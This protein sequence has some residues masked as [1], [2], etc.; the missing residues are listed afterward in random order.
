MDKTNEE[1]EI[2]NYLWCVLSSGI[3]ELR[4][5][6]KNEVITARQRDYHTTP[7]HTTIINVYN[8]QIA[9]VQHSTNNFAHL[10]LKNPNCFKETIKIVQNFYGIKS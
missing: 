8:D 6:V 1:K 4:I 7:N 10:D 5:R 3:P 9:I 2:I